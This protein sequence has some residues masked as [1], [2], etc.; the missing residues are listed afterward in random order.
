MGCIAQSGML[1][2]TTHATRR[3]AQLLPR[4]RQNMMA[5]IGTSHA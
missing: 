2:A 4:H 5:E 3:A 1:Q